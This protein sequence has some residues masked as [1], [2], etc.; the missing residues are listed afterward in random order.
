M[1]KYCIYY[2]N[3]VEVNKVSEANTLDEA[4]TYCTENTKGHDEIGDNDNCWEG[5]GNNFHY[6]V[7]EGDY[8]IKDED[9][10][11]VDF[12]EPVYMTKQYY[13]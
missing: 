6:E 8:E 7:Y 3:N 4:K 11:L 5:R 13:L 12:K 9:G 10:D 1:G 2:N